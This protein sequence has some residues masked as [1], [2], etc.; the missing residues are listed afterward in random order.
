MSRRAR[1]LLPAVPAATAYLFALPSC[2]RH[3]PPR[4]PQRLPVSALVVDATAPLVVD[5]A[6]V[7]TRIWHAGSRIW[8]A[9]AISKSLPPIVT[10][11][12]HR[13]CLLSPP[14]ESSAH[15]SVAGVG[16]ADGDSTSS[17]PLVLPHR[18]RP[19]P[20]DEVESRRG[21]RRCESSVH[22]RPAP[23]TYSRGSVSGKRELRSQRHAFPSWGSR[24]PAGARL[25]DGWQT[26]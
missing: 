11:R 13:L 14:T 17:P 16:A 12:R 21:N 6:L 25:E 7:D 10:A 19:P 4:P 8:W 23:N 20:N 3:L 18:R 26:A 24:L 5:A 15:G 22:K 9:G 1:E 2:R